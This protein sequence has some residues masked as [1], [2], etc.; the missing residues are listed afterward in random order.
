MFAFRP[1]EEETSNV[2]VVIA[3]MLNPIS[4]MLKGHGITCVNEQLL[5]L[6]GILTC[7]DID[8]NYASG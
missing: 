7:P 3:I 6:L 4:T 1:P 5:T 2:P 8:I